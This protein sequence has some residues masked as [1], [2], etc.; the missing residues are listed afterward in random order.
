MPICL[1]FSFN[2]VCELKGV[3]CQFE[4]T[5]LNLIE[6]KLR[7]KKIPF[8]C[9][10]Q[11]IYYKH[12]HFVCRWCGNHP[13]KQDANRTPAIWIAISILF[14]H[15]WN[16]WVLMIWR[17]QSVQG[18]FAIMAFLLE[19]LYLWAVATISFN[20]HNTHKPNP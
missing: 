3:Y 4:S 2:E 14:R 19:N 11:S 15:M 12:T 10:P 8:G 1:S 16:V 17:F 20:P 6:W 5:I 18:H 13:H 7:L 9:Y